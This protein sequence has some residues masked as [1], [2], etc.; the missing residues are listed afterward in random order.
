MLLE[1]VQQSRLMSIRAYTYDGVTFTA[2]NS[3]QLVS[4]N[5]GGEI[6]K[7]GANYIFSS[8][9]GGGKCE[10]LDL[11]ELHFPLLPPI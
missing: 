3:A 7:Y 11:M 5:N 1:L 4:S 2:T 8:G 6:K 9:F 10:F